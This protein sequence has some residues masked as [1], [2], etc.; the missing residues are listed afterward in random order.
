MGASVCGVGDGEWGIVDNH[1][2]VVARSTVLL[3]FLSG[4]C[5]RDEVMEVNDVA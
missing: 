2:K 3:K 5:E 1:R 4:I